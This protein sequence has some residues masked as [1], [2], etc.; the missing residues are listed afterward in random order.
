VKNKKI[1]WVPKINLEVDL[2]ML[3]KH[4]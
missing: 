4:K 3:S 1:G 2:K